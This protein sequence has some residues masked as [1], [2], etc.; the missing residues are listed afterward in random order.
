VPTI[1]AKAK[2]VGGCGA[3]GVPTMFMLVEIELPTELKA[4]TRYCSVTPLA[5]A[6]TK[7]F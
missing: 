3:S 7:R 5:G 1:G 4:E 6:V 2:F